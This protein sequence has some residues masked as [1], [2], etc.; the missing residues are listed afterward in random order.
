M[1]N[2][3]NSNFGSL[4]RSQKDDLGDLEETNEDGVLFY[5]NNGGFPIDEFTW[6][7]M[8]SHV[9]KLHPDSYEMVNK[10]RG[11]KSLSEVTDYSRQLIYFSY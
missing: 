6:D 7:R 8:W 11:K 5:V 3:V 9:A 2:E 1:A 10:I 4:S